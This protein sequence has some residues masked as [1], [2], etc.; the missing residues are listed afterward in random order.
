MSLPPATLEID[1]DNPLTGFVRAGERYLGSVSRTRGGWT[2]HTGEGSGGHEQQ[3][4]AQQA[5]EQVAE[6]WGTSVADPPDSGQLD[7][8]VRRETIC[9]RC[10]KRPKSRTQA[11][12][13]LCHAD[14]QREW[15]KRNPAA[16]G[17]RLL[18]LFELA[19]KVTISRFDHGVRWTINATA[20]CADHHAGADVLD[21]AVR[22]VGASLAAEEN[23]FQEHGNTKR[24]EDT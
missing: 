16:V 21:D 4:T 3:L 5:A 2:F 15:R 19:E 8:I 22:E 1:P 20:G 11:Y 23:W 13:L 18:R 7:P 6:I 9:P 14:Y 12:C 10:R 24:N 17:R